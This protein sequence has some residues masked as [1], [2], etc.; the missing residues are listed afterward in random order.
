MT[1][2]ARRFP[3][4]PGL[5]A[6]LTRF[7]WRRSPAL[8]ALFRRAYF[9]YKR[10]LE[11]PY[12]NLARRSPALF[13]GGHVLD[14]GANIGYTASV[15]A[16]AV[17]PGFGVYAFEP[18]PAN[19]EALEALARRRGG[20][21]IRPVRAAVGERAGEVQLWLN[22]THPGDH[23]IRTGSLEASAS[24][25]KFSRSE[26][27]RQVS[28]DEFVEAMVPP[29][30][31]VRFVKI[32]VQGFE[33]PVCLGMKRLLAS[34][35]HPLCVAIEYDPAMMRDIGF[36]PADCLRLLLDHGFELRVLRRNGETVACAASELP[37]HLGARGYCDLL[38]TR[39][40]RP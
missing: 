28:I 10:H 33:L 17:E 14:V 15:F 35:A 24:S 22:E 39:G 38:F 6:A 1:S 25:G 40:V 7:G 21:V 30:A 20:G 5:Y 3:T 12:Y 32:D 18:E 13:Q 23:R 37:A 36:D 26:A 11:D 29:L 8:D 27:V 4:L 19:F 34:G 31:P 9:L 16:D 2:P